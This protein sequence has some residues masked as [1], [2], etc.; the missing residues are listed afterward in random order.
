MKTRLVRLPALLLLSFIL[1]HSSFCLPAH[2]QGTAF[3]YQGQLFDNGSPA[4]GNYA[5]QFTLYT[6][7]TTMVVSVGPL[8]IAPV[9]V[10][11]GLFTVLLDFGPGEFTGAPR[12]L[13]IYAATNSA[14]PP[15][16]P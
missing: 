7:S 2:A 1:H 8:T 13:Q 3:T 5:M 12:W 10:S 15:T 16:S 4:N 9:T 14:S 11:N 6:N